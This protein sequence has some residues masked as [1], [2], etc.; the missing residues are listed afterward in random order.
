MGI[1]TK[2]ILTKL[3]QNN[4]VQQPQDNKRKHRTSKRAKAKTAPKINIPDNFLEADKQ[5]RTQ[6]EGMQFEKEWLGG[7][8]QREMFE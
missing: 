2:E 6:I 8:E 7:I 1:T 3:L 4:V 5:V